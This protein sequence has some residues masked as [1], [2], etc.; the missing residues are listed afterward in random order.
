[1]RIYLSG[2][3]RSGWQDRVKEA[4]GHWHEFADP[5]DKGETPDWTWREYGAWDFA[6][7]QTCD[8]VFAYIEASNPSGYGLAVEIGYAH[9][10]GKP[11]VLAMEQDHPQARYLSIL[12]CA[13][14]VSCDNLE[15]AI[16]I[17]RR[18]AW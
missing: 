7:I 1:M 18:L 10:L 9:G 8:L 15:Q 13:A 17:V 11:V 16:D 3:M 4:I 6:H 12:Q 2:G 5:R 14:T